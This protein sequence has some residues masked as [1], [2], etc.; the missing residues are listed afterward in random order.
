M[1][2]YGGLLVG[3]IHLFRDVLSVWPLIRIMEIIMKLVLLKQA[4]TEKTL[5][6]SLLYFQVLYILKLSLLS[7]IMPNVCV[8]PHRRSQGFFTFTHALS[9][10]KSALG[11]RMVIPYKKRYYYVLWLILEVNV[12]CCTKHN[13]LSLIGLQVKISI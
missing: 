6:L 1:Y 3:T 8:I 5:K 11:S 13:V 7:S 10:G 2:Q 9:E 4:N 12:Y